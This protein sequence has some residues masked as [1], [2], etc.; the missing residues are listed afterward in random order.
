MQLQFKVD[1]DLLDKRIIK[2]YGSQV[3]FLKVLG[4]TR[5]NFHYKLNAENITI[6]SIVEI[7]NVLEISDNQFKRY[8]LA[9]K[10]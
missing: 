7:C 5:Q 2:M 8:F 6:K 3:N 10:N 4:M 1:R 9:R